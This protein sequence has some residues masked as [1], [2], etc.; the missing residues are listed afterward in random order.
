MIQTVWCIIRIITYIDHSL[1]RIEGSS[2][3]DE[4]AARHTRWPAIV[5]QRIGDGSITPSPWKIESE[6]DTAC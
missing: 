4:N 2:N 1:K 3:L 5:T 6:M